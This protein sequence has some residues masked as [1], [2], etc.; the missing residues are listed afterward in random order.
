MSHLKLLIEVKLSIHTVFLLRENILFIE[1]WIDY[2][3]SIGFQ[4]F[5]LYDNSN[6]SGNEGAA[7]GFNKYNYNFH[8]ITEHISAELL[9]IKIA[10]ILKT[11]GD[12]ITYIY[13]EPRD[14]DGKVTYSQQAAIKDYITRYSD[15]SDWTA[16]IDIDEFIF[17]RT[18]LNEIVDKCDLEGIKDICLLQKKFDDRFNN[19]GVPVTHIVD[20]IEGID[21]SA[22]GPK[23]ILKNDCFNLEETEYWNVHRLPKKMGETLIGDFNQL[24]FNHYNL[25]EVQLAWMK[26]FY[27][28]TTDFRLNA[29]CYDLFQQ[30]TSLK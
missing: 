15:E 16:F 26:T 4:H 28:T 9:Q 18:P 22:W 5:F 27:N 17:S 3:L 23:H 24:R 11:F 25:N 20:C 6:S 12:A 13:W 21:T 2:H 10:A 14:S 30:A 19:L 8:K 29:R 1:E 7:P